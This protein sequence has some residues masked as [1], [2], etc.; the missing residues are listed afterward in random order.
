[1]LGTGGAEWPG[2]CGQVVT[3]LSL[4][5]HE[6]LL[7]THT[8]TSTSMHISLIVCFDMHCEASRAANLFI[9]ANHCRFSLMLKTQQSSAKKSVEIVI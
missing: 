6:V 9:R 8:Y 2:G 3:H 1:M 7:H 5:A 4:L